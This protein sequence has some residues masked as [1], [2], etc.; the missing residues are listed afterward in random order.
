DRATVYRPCE[1]RAGCNELNEEAADDRE[2]E[3]RELLEEVRAEQVEDPTEELE[4]HDS[5]SDRDTERY[6]RCCHLAHSLPLVHRLLVRT[7][8]VVVDA[9]VLVWTGRSLSSDRNR[10]RPDR[11]VDED[12]A[13]HD[14]GD[15]S[16][17]REAKSDL[18]KLP[19]AV[20][21]ENR[22]QAGESS[23]PTGE[24][25]LDQ[26][27]ALVAESEGGLEQHQHDEARDGELTGRHD[28]GHDHV[29][30][31]KAPGLGGRWEAVAQ[32]E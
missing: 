25:E 11:V 17:R 5:D 8:E 1:A 24:G 26:R 6:P 27:A 19:G 13:D 31:G 22:A 15:H 29:R 12:R 14:P 16:D 9:K 7:W 2:G 30:G 18:D 23:V 21:L 10:G 28:P 4:Q 20:L 32:K 3:E